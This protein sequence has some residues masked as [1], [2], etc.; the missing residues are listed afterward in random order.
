M[1][2]SNRSDRSSPAGRPPAAS[3]ARTAAGVALAVLAAAASAARGQA[4]VGADGHANDVNNRLGSNGYNAPGQTGNRSTLN[5]QLSTDHTSGLSGFHGYTGTSD[6]NV[7]QTDTQNR[8]FEQFERE[9]APVDYA[10]PTTGTPNYA[11]YYAGQ[12]YVGRPPAG[13]VPTANG[14]YT[15]APPKST[16][17]GDPGDVRLPAINEVPPDRHGTGVPV[18]GPVGNGASAARES[19]SPLY[20]VRPMQAA[21]PARP[22]PSADVPP[23]PQQAAVPIIAPARQSEQVAE[24]ERRFAARDANGPFVITS[25]VP[26]TK[27]PGLANLLRTAEGQMRSGQFGQSVDT[28]D[29]AAEVAPNNPFVPL[30]RGF[31]ELGASYYGRAEAD[32]TRA[33]LPEP[34]LLAAQYDLKGFLGADRL[35]FVRKDLVD[36]GATEQTARPYLLL[37]YVEHN[38]GADD[39]TVTAKD[40]DIAQARGGNQRLI[41]LMREAWNLKAAAK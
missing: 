25:F 31:A 10:R 14:A 20:G 21:D 11:P 36:I 16:L 41:D 27:S 15:S 30:G 39:A 6:P 17:N 29:T 37:A 18:P 35:K 22:V 5:T 7:V 3:L 13:L 40:L 19:V 9:S 2:K 12:S 28:Y 8:G 34:A 4:R 1:E 33:I 38:T 26:G 24:L 32:L 23:V